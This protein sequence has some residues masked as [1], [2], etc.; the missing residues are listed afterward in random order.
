MWIIQLDFLSRA[1]NIFHNESSISK[2][3]YKKSFADK[4]SVPG[5]IFLFCSL[6]FSKIALQSQRLKS[7]RVKEIRKVHKIFNKNFAKVLVFDDFFFRVKHYV[8]Q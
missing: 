7:K 5:S 3:I 1:D 6:Y 4:I 2:S 8:P